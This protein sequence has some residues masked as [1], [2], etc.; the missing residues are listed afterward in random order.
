MNEIVA[1]LKNI[2][3]DSSINSVVLISGKPGCFIA[4]ADIS[5]IQ[6]FKTAEDGYKI[7]SEAQEILNS[8]E[9]SQKPVVAA[10]QGTCVGGGLEVHNTINKMI[11]AAG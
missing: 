6:N 1:L 11:F 2:E 9:K 7:S 4:G 3:G 5:M 8:I 10:I